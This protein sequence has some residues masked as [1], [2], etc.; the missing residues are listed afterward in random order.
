VVLVGAVIGKHRRVAQVVMARTVNEGFRAVVRVDGRV[1]TVLGPGRHRL[2]GPFWRRRVETVDVREQL[3]IVT[4]QEVAAADLPGVKISAALRWSVAD[5]AAWL[6]VA[7]EPEDQVRLAFQIGIRDWAAS[8]DVAELV[9]ARADASATLEAVARPVA[10]RV[11]ATVIAATVRDIVVPTELRRA[12]LAVAT[13]RLDGMAQLERAR[14]ETAALRAAANG[15]RL[16][17]DNPALLQLR[18]VEAASAGGGQIVLRLG[19]DDPVRSPSG[20][21]GA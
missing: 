20:D 5:P 4:G 18:T 9:A 16:L 11:G 21:A 17:A 15:A 13:A 8:L 14:S 6:G 19:T 3:M 1:R 12:A 2:P 10:E 7:Q